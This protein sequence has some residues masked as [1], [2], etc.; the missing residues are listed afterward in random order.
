MNEKP[1]I[2]FKNSLG[3]WIGRTMKL[4]EHRL[5][6]LLAENNIDLSKMQFIVLSKIAENDG[7]CQSQLAFY[8][9]RDKSS[10]TR[11]INTLIS[12]GYITK[13]PS[14]KDKR[15]NKIYIS[16]QGIDILKEA[17]PH[18]KKMTEFVEEGLTPE[19]IES[20]KKILERIQLNV[21]NE[22]IGPFFN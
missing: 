5:E 16:E 14:K 17:A 19:E 8:T 10:L 12:K 18:F 20:T 9:N 15:K 21:T 2:E 3:P 4:I 22:K 6:D 11:M 7:L 13:C 1:I